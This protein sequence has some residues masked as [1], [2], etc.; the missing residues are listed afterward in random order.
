MINFDLARGETMRVDTGCIVSMAES[1]SYDIQF[2][3]GF[4]NALFG[5]EGL[6][7]ATLTGPGKVTLQTLPFSRLASRVMAAAGGRRDESK[8]LG[9]RAGRS[10]QRGLKYCEKE[11]PAYNFAPILFDQ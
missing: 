6:F 10:H 2:V 3:G 4:R 8:G 1:V 11:Q 9:K 7:Y 5:G